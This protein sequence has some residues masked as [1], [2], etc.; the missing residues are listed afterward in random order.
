MQDKPLTKDDLVA[1]FCLKPVKNGDYRPLSRVLKALGIRLVGGTTRWSVI[2]TALGLA[3]KQ[4]P[5]RETELKEALL[6]AKTAAAHSQVDQVSER[7]DHAKVC[8]EPKLTDH[9]FR[10][11]DTLENLLTA[12][13]FAVAAKDRSGQT[14]VPNYGIRLLA[15]LRHKRRVRKT[16]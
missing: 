11:T 2:W 3:T 8:F 16:S 7:A 6:D 15:H 5:Q 13:C 10:N 9:L 12:T 4:E 1:F 14:S